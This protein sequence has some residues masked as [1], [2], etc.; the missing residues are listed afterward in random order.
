MPEAADTPGQGCGGTR[1]R[2]G[3][4]ALSPS[5]R[6]MVLIDRAIMDH[7]LEAMLTACALLTGLFLVLLMW[8]AADRRWLSAWFGAYLL[9]TSSQ[10]FRMFAKRGFAPKTTREAERSL[11]T[12]L[13]YNV[14]HGTAWACAFVLFFDAGSSNSLWTLLSCLGVIC[15]G[16][17]LISMISVWQ[18]LALLLPSMLTVQALLLY[19]GAGG[20][21]VI[22][23]PVI[24]ALLAVLSKILN[25]RM[26]RFLDS[27]YREAEQVGELQRRFSSLAQNLEVKTRFVSVVSHDLRQPVH[28]MGLLAHELDKHV[29]DAQGRSLL[30][31]IVSAIHSLQHSFESL[32]DLTRL[33]SN[34]TRPRIAR[35]SLQA[36]FDRLESEFAPQ[37][38]QRGIFL[39]FAPTRLVTYSDANM[40]H[41]VLGNFISNALS[42]CPES[43]VVVGCRR[44]GE[45]VDMLVLDTGPGIPEAECPEIFLPFH[46]LA[47]PAGLTDST[48]HAGLG[49][50]IAK[51]TAEALGCQIGVRSTLGRGSCFWLRV[52]RADS[53][54]AGPAKLATL[55]QRPSAEDVLWGCRIAVLD[56]DPVVRNQ[57]VTLFER[58]G[59]RV[60]SSAGAADFLRA[61][62]PPQS[63]PDLAVVDYQ[64]G[65]GEIDGI[66]A[67]LE[68]RNRLARSVPA[69]VVSA[70]TSVAVGLAAANAGLKLVNKPV[71][72]AQLRTI[73]SELKRTGSRGS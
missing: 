30:S 11:R 29:A 61:N 46:R 31:G 36:V 51:R 73:L 68:L 28:A 65:A 67:L 55:S 70:D 50:A 59:C 19:R 53:T 72:P 14:A 54:A 13:L 6:R 40:L 22:A 25:E 42:H 15:S 62:S 45:H 38:R 47:T 17:L 56:D 1:V 37:A 3:S 2:A 39:R 9:L 16:G 43:R 10:F 34:A 20:G 26:S 52:P 71:K 57:T 35:V 4:S 21:L 27:R 8:N 64:L 41:C 32:L 58:W 49:L 48:G 66:S 63:P 12:R 69:L 5:V 7:Q 60:N 24:T 33:E 18:Y 44:A 23:I